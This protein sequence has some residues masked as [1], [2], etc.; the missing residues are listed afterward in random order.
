MGGN[1]ARSCLIVPGNNFILY[2]NISLSTKGILSTLSQELRNKG[3]KNEH[4][5]KCNT[6]C[7]PIQFKMKTLHFGDNRKKTELRIINLGSDLNNF[8]ILDQVFLALELL[9]LW[10]G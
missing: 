1:Y 3:S 9:T 7:F 8:V 5:I 2:S 4:N 10:T 6:L